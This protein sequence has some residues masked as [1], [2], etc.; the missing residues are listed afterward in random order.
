[1]ALVRTRISSRRCPH[2]YTPNARLGRIQLPG[3]RMMETREK[4]VATY[5]LKVEDRLLANNFLLQIE[6]VVRDVIRSRVARG[7]GP[8]CRVSSGPAWALLD[9]AA[10]KCPPTRGCVTDTSEKESP[11]IVYDLKVEGR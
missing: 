8:E 10:W 1:M 7:R 2:A 3:G 11:L 9:H 5:D 4:G 6:G